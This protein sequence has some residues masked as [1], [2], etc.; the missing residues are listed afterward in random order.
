[1][2]LFTNAVEKFGLPKKVRSDLGGENVDVWRYMIAQ[3]G[4]EKVVIETFS[5]QFPGR[6]ET[7][8]QSRDR[9][10]TC[11]GSRLN[12]GRKVFPFGFNDV[13]LLPSTFWKQLV[14]CRLTFY[15]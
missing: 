15:I 1:L 5:C 14:S 8:R 7:R 6:R 12:V 4:D 13:C 10:Y 3:H 2:S 11:P 9:S